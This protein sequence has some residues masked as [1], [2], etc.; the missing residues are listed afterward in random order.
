MKLRKHQQQFSQI[1]DRIIAGEPIRNVIGN[2]TPG[3]GKSL[4]ALLATKLI[5]AGLSDKICWVVPRLTLAYQAETNFVDPFFRK[6]LNHGSLIRSSTNEDNPCRGLSGFVTTYY[7]LA[8]DDGNTVLMDFIRHRHVLILDEFHHVEDTS[9]WHKALQPLI[10]RAAFVIYLSGTMERG[11]KHKIAFIDYIEGFLGDIIPDLRNTN[12]T[13]VINYSRRDALEEQAILPVKFHLSG[14]SATWKEFDP[15]EGKDKTIRAQVSTDDK[16]L[17][18]RALFTALSTE[19]SDQLLETGMSDWVSYKRTHPR[20]K[21][22]AVAANIPHAKSVLGKIRKMG[23]RSEIATSEDSPEA[24]RCIKSFKNTNLDIL[25]GVGMF[26]EGFDC[27]PLTHIIPLTHVRSRPWILQLIARA[28]RVDPHA[29]PYRSQLAYVYAPD[30]IYFREI[31]EHVYNEQ[32]ATVASPSEKAQK[33]LFPGEQQRSYEPVGSELN[34]HREIFWGSPGAQEDI[35]MTPSEISDGLREEI[36]SYV[37]RHSIKTGRKAWVV[38]G[39]VKAEFG[40]SR[41]DMTI[42]ELRTALAYVKRRWP[43]DN[44]RPRVSKRVTI[45]R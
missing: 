11:D 39:I 6:M 16:R 5:K 36:E 31:M 10:D 38:N 28:V 44:I 43:K 7:A 8:V 18:S 20:S 2:I 12:T 35:P 14:G 33:S 9:L 15:K 13:A 1:I 30:D 42:P 27:K 29:G 32:I 19:F 41:K 3:G 21:I 4:F 34:G 24:I 37:R 23:F 17:S 26:S 25:V 40:K 45:H 22:I